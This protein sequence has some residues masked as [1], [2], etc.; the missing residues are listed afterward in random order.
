MNR[1][2]FWTDWSQTSPG[3]YRAFMDGTDPKQIT[4]RGQVVWPNGVCID[5][6]TDRLYWVD[7]NL[8]YIASADLDGANRKILQDKTVSRRRRRSAAQ[9]TQ[10]ADGGGVRVGVE[11]ER[12][13]HTARFNSYPGVPFV[14]MDGAGV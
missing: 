8:D 5:Y 9:R 13:A 10:P 2:M 11:V 1:Y 12:P 7:A 14:C 4:G 3:I 6:A